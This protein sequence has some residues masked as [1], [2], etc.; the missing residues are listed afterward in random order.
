MTDGQPPPRPFARAAATLIGRASSARLITPAALGLL[1]VLLLAACGGP[2]PRDDSGAIVEP[3]NIDALSLRIGDCFDDAAGVVGEGS[4][5]SI[6][7]LPCSDPHDNE[8]Y[9]AID[10]PADGDDIYPGP[11]LIDEFAVDACFEA[12]EPYVGLS[13]EF[14]RF[15]YGW[16]T[17][18]LE[19][20]TDAGD[21]EI[22]YLLWD[23]DLLKLEGSKKGSRE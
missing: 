23:I 13:Y 17:P 2:D 20:W 4:F 12:F 19:G 14:S 7:V 22:L 1:A 9:A 18:T 3:A 8:I 21:H 5:E 16:M 15:D 6:D 10:F 11:L